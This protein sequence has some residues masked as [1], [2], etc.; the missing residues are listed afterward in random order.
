MERWK[1][2]GTL[3]S[4]RFRGIFSVET[5]AELILPPLVLGKWV[6]KNEAPDV[7]DAEVGP[8]R[9]QEETGCTDALRK[10]EG[11]SFYTPNLNSPSTLPEV[12]NVAGSTA[13]NWTTAS[14]WNP[15]TNLWGWLRAM[16]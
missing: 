15:A 5:H 11:T 3:Q 14:V 13:S 1:Y 8:R 12:V 16:A 10:Q 2:D 4:N 9:C 7:G 6:R